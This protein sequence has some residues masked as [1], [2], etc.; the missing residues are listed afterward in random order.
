MLTAYLQ[1]RVHERTNHGDI[2]DDFGYD[3]GADRYSQEDV[4]ED[5]DT[6]G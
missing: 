5:E 2:A 1:R 6:N 3:G 4:L